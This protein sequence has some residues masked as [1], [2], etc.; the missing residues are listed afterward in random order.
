MGWNVERLSTR[1]AHRATRLFFSR[2]HTSQPAVSPYRCSL[3]TRMNIFFNLRG[4]VV[5]QIAEERSVPGMFNLLLGIF[6]QVARTLHVLCVLHYW[7]WIVGNDQIINKDW[8]GLIPLQCFIIF[9]F[10]KFSYLDMSIPA[11]WAHGL[12]DVL[13]LLLAYLLISRYN[14]K[15]ALSTF[16]HQMP[17]TDEDIH[18]HFTLLH[19][20][21]DRR[22]NPICL[23]IRSHSLR[24]LKHRKAWHIVGTMCG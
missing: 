22:N 3:R 21:Y 24:P 14:S 16:Y 4:S 1:N 19:S 12:T 13:M 6:L 17:L 18:W 9:N 15:V 7:C 5:R 8:C 20:L 2:R 23:D 10:F 11:I